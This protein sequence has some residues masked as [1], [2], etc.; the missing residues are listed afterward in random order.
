M[1][2]ITIK[3]KSEMRLKVIAYEMEVNYQRRDHAE[4]YVDSLSDD[5]LES[6]YQDVLDNWV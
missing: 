4:D 2:L 3:F 6:T 5:E 1:R